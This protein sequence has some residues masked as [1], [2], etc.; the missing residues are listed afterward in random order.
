MRLLCDIESAAGG[1]P[2]RARE[3]RHRLIRR[4]LAEGADR[5]G[6]NVEIDRYIP[7]SVSECDAVLI[8]ELW[9]DGRTIFTL[10]SSGNGELPEFCF[11]VVDPGEGATSIA[12]CEAAV[13]NLFQ[14]AHVAQLH[15]VAPD[16]EDYPPIDR[17]DGKE[18]RFQIALMPHYDGKVEFRVNLVD[19]SPGGFAEKVKLEALDH[20]GY[21]VGEPVSH[22]LFP[23]ASHLPDEPEPAEPLS[24]EHLESLVVA[25]S[26]GPIDVGPGRWVASVAQGSDVFWTYGELYFRLPLEPRANQKV[27]VSYVH[28][29]EERVR[30][31]VDAL[32]NSGYSVWLDREDLLG[33]RRW[34]SDIRDGIKNALAM[35]ACFSSAFSARDRTYMNVEL[36]VA[37]EE[38]QMRRSDRSWFVPVRLDECEI[39]DRYIGGGETLNDIE[40]IDLFPDEHRGYERLISVLRGIVTDR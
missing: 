8:V 40:A 28:S 11:S 31:L 1:I 32:R 26:T 20:Y 4:S 12:A 7:N 37:S 25:W 21:I 22:R 16:V 9:T 14:R 29:D 39:P 17:P 38:I 36:G 18:L 10:M 23:R 35:V 19:W 6:W 13:A 2:E 30:R 27:F 34:K 3:A 24:G 5:L 33:G 15:G